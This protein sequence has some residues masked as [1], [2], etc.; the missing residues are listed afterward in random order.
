MLGSAEPAVHDDPMTVHHRVI[1]LDRLVAIG[2]AHFNA[3]R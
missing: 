2:N 1:E 3:R